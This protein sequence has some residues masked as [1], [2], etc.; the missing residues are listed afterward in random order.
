MIDFVEGQNAAPEKGMP[1]LRQYYGLSSKLWV[2]DGHSSKDKWK[3]G[4]K[5]QIFFWVDSEFIRPNIDVVYLG[6]ENVQYGQDYV[7]IPGEILKPKPQGL[8]Q[9]GIRGLPMK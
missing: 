4:E 5:F 7:A 9:R 8:N 6:N 3:R 1:L 2:L